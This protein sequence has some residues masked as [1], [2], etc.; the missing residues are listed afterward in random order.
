LRQKFKQEQEK[1]LGD[2]GRKKEKKKRR[3]GNRT[4][5]LKFIIFEWDRVQATHT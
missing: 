2:R 5:L 3:K 4:K 1:D